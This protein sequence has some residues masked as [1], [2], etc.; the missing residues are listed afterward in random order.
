ML[1]QMGE[2]AFVVSDVGGE[3]FDTFGVFGEGALDG[4]DF[5]AKLRQFRAHSVNLPRE[6]LPQHRFRSSYRCSDKILHVLEERHEA[7][8]RERSWFSMQWEFGRTTRFFLRRHV[9]KI[10]KCRTYVQVT[11][12]SIS[13]YVTFPLVNVS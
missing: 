5:A 8:Y 9:R 6:F 10:N 2:T 4:I 1:F 7:L 3:R 11:S 12:E 13:E